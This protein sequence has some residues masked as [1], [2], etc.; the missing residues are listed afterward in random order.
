MLATIVYDQAFMKEAKPRDFRI[1]IK[2]P[3][4]HYYKDLKG[5]TLYEEEI[6]LNELFYHT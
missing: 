4:V 3:D 1:F 5:T 6:P 2:K